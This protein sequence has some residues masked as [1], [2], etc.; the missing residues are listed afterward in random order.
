MFFAIAIVTKNSID[1]IV[2]HYTKC[3]LLSNVPF[4]S[5]SSSLP[6]PPLSFRFTHTHFIHI[7]FKLK[8]DPF[9]LIRLVVCLCMHCTY[10]VQSVAFWKQTPTHR[11]NSFYSILENVN[12]HLQHAAIFKSKSIRLLNGITCSC[13]SLFLSYCFTSTYY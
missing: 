7:F 9:Y 12:Q 3:V 13:D 6:P 5:F 4:I 10:C 2:K 1:L 11:L 8:S